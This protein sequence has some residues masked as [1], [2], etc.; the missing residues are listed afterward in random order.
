MFLKERGRQKNPNAFIWGKRFQLCFRLRL[1]NGRRKCPQN[2]IVIITPPQE[3]FGVFFTSN[4]MCIINVSYLFQR[5]LENDIK[6]LKTRNDCTSV[7]RTSLHVI[8][9]LQT[10]DI[11]CA[12]LNHRSLKYC[13]RLMK[14][15]MTLPLSSYQAF[16]LP[17]QTSQYSLNK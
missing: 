8:L 5:C 2:K 9:Q 11:M 3:H 15:R 6:S 14:E 12:L 13:I 16:G 4:K 17:D 1:E 10:T 7:S